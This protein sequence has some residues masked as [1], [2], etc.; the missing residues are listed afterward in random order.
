[1]EFLTQINDFLTENQS[2][3]FGPLI[4]V[5]ILGLVHDPSDG[6]DDAEPA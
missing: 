6:P 5:G 4:V 3:E 1:M 2:G